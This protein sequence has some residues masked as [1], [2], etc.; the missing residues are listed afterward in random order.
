MSKRLFW[1]AAATLALAACGGEDTLSQG[2]AVQPSTPSRSELTPR[3]WA[4]IAPGVW[5]RVRED[6]LREQAGIGVEALEFNLQQVRAERALLEEARKAS[7]KTSALDARLRQSD[8]EIQFLQAGIARARQEGVLEQTPTEL[9]TGSVQAMAGEQ[10]TQS[11]SFCGGYFG[12]DVQFSYG[13]AG[14]SVATQGNWTEFG[15]YG[16]NLKEYYVIAKAWLY[17]PGDYPSQADADQSTFSHTC[18]YSTRQVSAGAYPTFT[19]ILEGGGWLLGYGGC[20]ARTYK[21]W[22]Y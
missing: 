6:G 22:N 11:G 1:S 3:P 7:D 20:G 17:S 9:P 16:P 12:F 14:G 13:M 18:C 19:P 5:E 2:D 4:K 8:Q 15:P 21:V 10:G